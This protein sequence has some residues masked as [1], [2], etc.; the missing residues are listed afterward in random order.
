MKAAL[1]VAYSSQLEQ[2]AKQ[3]YPGGCSQGQGN[4]KPELQGI[5]YVWQVDGVS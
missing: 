4:S 1:I 2:A 3:G 5:A